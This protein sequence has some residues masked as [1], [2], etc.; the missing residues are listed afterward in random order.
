MVGVLHQHDGI[1]V[2]HRKDGALRFHGVA[3]SRHIPAL[4]RKRKAKYAPP[5]PNYPHAGDGQ[6][7]H[8]G[9]KGHMTPR[10]IRG[11]GKRKTDRKP[12]RTKKGRRRK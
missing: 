11:G 4:D 7:V 1:W 3:H 2:Y 12:K 9:T 6:P 8:T 5:N 10:K